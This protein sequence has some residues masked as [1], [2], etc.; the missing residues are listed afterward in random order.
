MEDV[1]KNIIYLANGKRIEPPRLPMLDFESLANEI[2]S[3]PDDADI[4]KHLLAVYDKLYN[5]VGD[6]NT[7]FSPHYGSTGELTQK[8]I[9]WRYMKNCWM[10]SK[11]IT[12]KR[13]VVP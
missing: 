13:V 4:R 6:Y 9:I 12:S 8:H 7:G 3:D 1:D 5:L 2:L 11:S 10:K